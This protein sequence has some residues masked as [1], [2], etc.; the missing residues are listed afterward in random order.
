[1]KTQTILSIRPTPKIHRGSPLAPMYPFMT[2]DERILIESAS[3][4]EGISPP[5][6]LKEAGLGLAMTVLDMLGKG[7]LQPRHPRQPTPKPTSAQQYPPR[8]IARD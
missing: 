8:K 3:Q 2:M 5:E 4:I 7:E 1:M 6:F